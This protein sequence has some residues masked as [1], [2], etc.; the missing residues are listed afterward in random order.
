MDDGVRS[1]LAEVAH[2]ADV[3]RTTQ[4]SR[5]WGDGERE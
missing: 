1:K 4:T 3:V 2:A 5:M